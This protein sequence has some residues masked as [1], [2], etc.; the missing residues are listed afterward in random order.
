MPIFN[1][2]IFFFYI[3]PL[4]S[5]RIQED[6][7]RRPYHLK[8]PNVRQCHMTWSCRGRHRGLVLRFWVTISYFIFKTVWNG[9]KHVINNLIVASRGLGSRK[10]GQVRQVSLLA[11]F[12]AGNQLYEIQCQGI[13]CGGWRQ[14]SIVIFNYQKS[15]LSI[16]MKTKVVQHVKNEWMRE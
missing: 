8:R 10:I 2:T 9:R 3:Q 5:G 15:L 1:F 13:G 4:P 11:R 6:L 16:D 12:L 7:G 14:K